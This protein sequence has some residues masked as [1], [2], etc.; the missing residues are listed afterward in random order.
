MMIR[1]IGRTVALSVALAVVGVALADETC[2]AELTAAIPGRSPSSVSGRAFIASI[3]PLERDAREAAIVEQILAGNI[4]SFLRRLVPIVVTA[5]GSADSGPRSA[6]LCVMPDYLAVGSDDDYVHMPMNL[7]SSLEIAR[8]LGFVLPTTRI[9]DAIHEQ[10]TYSF[11]PQPLAPGP[12]MVTPHY[13]LLHEARIRAQ[14][15]A[16]DA[17]LGVL[18]A[19][20]KKDVVLTSLLDLRTG[21]L[22]IYGWHHRDGTPIQPLSTVH[23]ASYADY[24]HGIRLVSQV[25]AIDGQR[26]T[27]LDA[28]QQ[29]GSAALFSSEGAIR[30]V[31]ALMSE[32][33]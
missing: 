23:Q 15:L 1:A 30:N 17:L 27:I 21:R 18:V 29:A 8:T 7:H 5:R 20:H 14:A 19:G 13:F 22:A 31:R 32:T 24:S 2:P 9:V 16:D 25:V 26:E 28:L 33:P 12:E 11:E 6:T 4:P 10:A 3:D